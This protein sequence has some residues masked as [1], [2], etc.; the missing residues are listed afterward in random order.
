MNTTSDFAKNES[1]REFLDRLKKQSIDPA[2]GTPEQLGAHIKSEFARYS[3]L[4][5][6]VGLTVE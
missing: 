1:F 2:T 3:R 6:A 5:K 4:I